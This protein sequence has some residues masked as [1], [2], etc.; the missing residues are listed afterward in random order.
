MQIQFEVQSLRVR[1]RELELENDRLKGK[2]N[3]ASSEVVS[4]QNEVS[5]IR[6]IEK[7]LRYEIFRFEK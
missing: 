7:E 5:K 1:V 4:L 3:G 6:S 2:V